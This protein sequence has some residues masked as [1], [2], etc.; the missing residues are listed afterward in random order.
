MICTPTYGFMKTRHCTS[1]LRML[2]YYQQTPIFGRETEEREL[3][4]Q[5]IESS[6]VGQARETFVNDFL[7][8]KSATHLL[9]IDEDM[10]FREDTLNILL[11]RQM[12]F[13]TCNYRMKIPP[14]RFTARRED[15][16]HVETTNKMDSL[17]EVHFTGMGFALIER[18]VCEAVSPP[19]WMNEWLDD[20]QAYSSEDR[21]FCVKARE[22]GFPVYVDHR[23]SRRIYHCGNWNYSFD[24]DFKPEQAIPYAER[25]K[26]SHD[27]H[28]T[29]DE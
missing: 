15:R 3:S 18:Q 8:K 16:S 19:R 29:N 11:S 22:A 27:E 9:F 12:P 4:Y 5:V 2:F 24:D 7:K 28:A 25:P 14:C 20:C 10:G 6:M 26:L 21:S 23:A 13:V 1:L 17:E